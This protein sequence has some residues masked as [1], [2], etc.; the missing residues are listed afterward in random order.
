VTVTIGATSGAIQVTP[1]NSC[2]DGTART[3]AV[4]VT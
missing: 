1:S 2:G 4:S 3:L